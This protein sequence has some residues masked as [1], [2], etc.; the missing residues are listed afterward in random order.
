MLGVK[1][2]LCLLRLRAYVQCE[3]R[4]MRGRGGVLDSA[5][6]S[7]WVSFGSSASYV[8]AFSNLAATSPA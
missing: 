5:E 4:D 1:D 6:L 3:E 7:A 8:V 2:G